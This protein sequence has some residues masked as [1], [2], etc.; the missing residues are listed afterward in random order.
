M[1]LL[2][3][4]SILLVLLISRTVTAQFHTVGFD[5]AAHA[6]SFQLNP[7]VDYIYQKE[8]GIPLLNNTQIF[9]G[10]TGFSLYD[11]FSSQGS[12]DQ[13]VY[14]T[15]QQLKN[16]DY[17]LINFR[18]D[19]FSYGYKD[20]LERLKYFGLYWEFDHFTN[21]PADLIRL[22]FEGNAS[23]LFEKYDAKYLASKTE[24]IQTIYY[25]VNKKASR[26]LSVGYRFKLYS[27]IINA[28]STGNK[29][30]FYTSEGQHNYY[31]HHLENIDISAESSGFNEQS[32]TQDYL[33][34]FLFSGNYGAGID[35]GINYR[36]SDKVH[37]S[38]SLLD[39]GF[40]YYTSDIN[41][42]QIKG[43]YDFEG[44]AMQFPED[45]FIDY[46]KQV[47]ANFKKEIQRG[48]NKKNYISYR[49]T[50][51][52][53]SLKY[54][55]GDLRHQSC[56]NFMNLKSEYNSFVGLTGFAQ[57]RPVKIHL[58]ISAFYEKKWSKYFYS[59]LNYTI[60]NY[61][62]SSIGL[63]L[64]ANLGRLQL[65]VSADNLIGLSDVSK[66]RKQAVQMGINIVKF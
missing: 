56:E 25:G 54:S 18:Q 4:L 12:F 26:D 16:T 9:A 41:A 28:Q 3:L 42:Y 23:H 38:A 13:K 30:T 36:L 24:L 45:G 5:F 34:K 29:G 32:T 66:S 1:K 46:W 40:I 15:V 61:S 33:N 7:G 60:D 11:L 51:L 20:D 53:T 57:Y 59:K 17:L 35:L 2:K 37:L 22:G 65:Y 48:E 39:L 52:Y 62:Y 14:Q 63:G 27:G 19:L 6:Q 8:L 47:K 21:I 49:P 64:V 55:L 50:S 31:V 10:N 44:V 58:G 43:S